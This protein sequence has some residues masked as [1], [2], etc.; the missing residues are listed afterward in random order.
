MA[1]AEEIA[2]RLGQH[3]G[4]DLE[5]DMGGPAAVFRPIAEVGDVLACGDGVPC[6]QAGQA[7][8]EVAVEGE[9]RLPFQI[10][11]Q[12]QG[13]AVIQRVGVIGQVQDAARQ[14]GIDRGACGRKDIDARV[15]GAAFRAGAVGELGGGID[16]AVF[17]VGA[18]A[19]AD[20]S[21]LMAGEPWIEGRVGE[22]GMSGCSPLVRSAM[23]GLAA[24]S[25]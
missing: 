18:E 19:V 9:E 7:G 20:A 6:V 10:M 24:T 21:G 2:P 8:G 15:H 5:V 14:R 1:D 11:L 23:V 16:A 4:H 17:A 12:D 25:G 3:A 22:G 13:V